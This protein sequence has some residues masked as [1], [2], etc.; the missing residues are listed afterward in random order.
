MIICMLIVYLTSS[1][2]MSP[3]LLHLIWSF[4]PPLYSAALLNVIL[5][6]GFFHLVCSLRRE[7]KCY[8]SYN[9]VSL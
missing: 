4:T 1:L 5:L 2:E 3:I 9:D 6:A 7:K 8:M